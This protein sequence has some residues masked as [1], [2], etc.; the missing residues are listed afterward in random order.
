MQNLDTEG[1]PGCIEEE[2]LRNDKKGIPGC[3]E[4]KPSGAGVVGAI[5][6]AMRMKNKP[7]PPVPPYLCC[8]TPLCFFT[9]LM[10]NPGCL[11]E[12]AITHPM[13]L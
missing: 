10:Y 2:K 7:I 8:N 13:P 1:I 11:E 12:D 6:F 9:S 5:Q 4:G 3:K